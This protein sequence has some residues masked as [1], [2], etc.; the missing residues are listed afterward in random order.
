MEMSLY[1]ITTLIVRVTLVLGVALILVR[2]GRKI[3]AFTRYEAVLMAMTAAVVLPL[4]MLLVPSWNVLP[5]LPAQW[6]NFEGTAGETAPDG[7]RVGEFESAPMT[8]TPASGSLVVQNPVGEALRFALDALRTLT[9]VQ[10]LLLAWGT[11]ALVVLLRSIHA[12]RSL[13]RLWSSAGPIDADAWEEVIE[14]AGDRVFLTRAVDVRQLSGIASPMTWGLWKPRL[15]L[16]VEASAWTRERKLNAL[17]HEFVHVRRRDAWH[18]AGALLFVSLFWFHPMAWMLRQQ[19]HV[20]RETSCDEA[21][22]EMGANPQEYAQMLIDVAKQMKAQHRTPLVAMTI[23][24]PS[25]LEGRILSVLD[26]KPGVQA[27]K[28][29]QQRILAAGWVGLALLVS[30]LSPAADASLAHDGDPAA[31]VSASVERPPMP[32]ASW[33]TDLPASTNASPATTAP[34]LPDVELEPAQTGPQDE[35]AT[36]APGDPLE[37]FFATA[38][39][40]MADAAL[41]E[42]GRTVAEMD[43][44]SWL[45]ASGINVSEVDLKIGE[46]APPNESLDEAMLRLSHRIE[47]AVVEEL[48]KTVQ[49]NPGTEKARKAVKAL[50]EIDS[51]ASREALERLGVKPLQ[52]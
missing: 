15:L 48:E 4:L 30:A 1:V 3:A 33:A 29:Y 8:S 17:M 44:S 16:P 42:L 41:A 27:A 18:D 52:R 20:L 7:A 13:S 38:G 24:R 25:Q 35:E 9:F 39:I 5:T 49:L 32:D 31:D 40:R 12:R 26:F 50:I 21:V 47:F 46:D 19:L 23:S 28:P 14:E 37:D 10:L 6:L 22:L 36:L 51:P 34:A 43:W 45:E 11:G 2:F